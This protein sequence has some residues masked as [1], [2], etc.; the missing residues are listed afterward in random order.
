MSK[1]NYNS[2]KTHSNFTA[3]QEDSF[4]DSLGVQASSVNVV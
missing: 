3:K 1:P 2:N 4:F